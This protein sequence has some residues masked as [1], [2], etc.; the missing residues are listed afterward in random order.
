MVGWCDRARLIQA[1]TIIK[2]SKFI[3]C[4]LQQLKIYPNFKKWRHEQSSNA[5]YIILYIQNDVMLFENV[6]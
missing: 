4:L 5:D 3:F 1:N 2:S 6:M